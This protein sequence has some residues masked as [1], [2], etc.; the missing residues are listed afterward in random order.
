MLNS[1]IEQKIQKIKEIFKS[2]KVIVAF[3]GGVDSTLVA[4][5]A[6][7]F[8]NDVLC[9]TFYNEIY[10][11]DEYVKANKIAKELNVKWKK[12]EISNIPNEF[13]KSHPIN[14]CYICKKTVFKHL[15]DLKNK[16]NYDLIV[17]G[18]NYDDIKEHRPG[19]KALS[20]L[21]ICSPLMEAKL[22]KNEIRLIAKYN[23]LSVADQ[24]P[25]TCLL[26]RIP[27]KQ[28]I[29]IEK[30]NMI[31][32]SEEFLKQF[33]NIKVVRVRHYEIYENTHLARIEIP[34]E[35]IQNLLCKNSGIIQK[36]VNELKKIG[37]TYITF[38]LEGYRTGSMDVLK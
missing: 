28:K 6:K 33:L 18:T 21:K 17:D 12:I 23:N 16:I 8:A 4:Y 34:L 26:S 7:K 1:T 27:Y 13:F 38:D 35:Q 20:E 9:C 31:K 14:R 24:P 11:N 32:K 36:I 15:I 30:L 25:S 19:L 3:S 5:F 10:L 37:Y 29:T 22:N 2:K